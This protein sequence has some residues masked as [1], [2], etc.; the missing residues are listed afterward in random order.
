MT[1]DVEEMMLVDVVGYVN[2]LIAGIVL[3]MLNV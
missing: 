1:V 3:G 2:D